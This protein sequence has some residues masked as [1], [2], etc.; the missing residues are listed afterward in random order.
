MVGTRSVVLEEEEEEPEPRQPEDRD[1]PNTGHTKEEL[2]RMAK[3]VENEIQR[4]E[5]DATKLGCH[6]QEVED[7]AEVIESI[8]TFARMMKDEAVDLA[9]RLR[10]RETAKKAP[11]AWN[12]QKRKRCRELLGDDAEDTETLVKRES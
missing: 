1:F 5:A 8:E 7:L 2:R 6:A 12:E 10:A 9:K 3:S 4:R 11:I